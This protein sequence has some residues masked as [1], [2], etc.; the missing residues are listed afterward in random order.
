MRGRAELAQR[1]ET[2]ILHV[3]ISTDA[4]RLF[5]TPIGRALGSFG[6]NLAEGIGYEITSL[7]YLLPWL[8]MIAF[9]FAFAVRA[10]QRA[11]MSGAQTAPPLDGFARAIPPQA[12]A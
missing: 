7:P 10:L 11:P 3:A 12:A 4:H 5:W 9:A 1:V 8:F 2:E 6:G